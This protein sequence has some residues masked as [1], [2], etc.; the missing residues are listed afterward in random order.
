MSTLK[1]VLDEIKREENEQKPA[2]TTT[3]ETKTEETATPAEET[4]PGKNPEETTAPS[5]E[6]PAEET[7]AEPEQKPKKE[8][9]DDKFARAEY[10]FKRQLEKQNRK[11]ADELKE[12]D[13]KYAAL[14]KKF[15]D[16]EKKLNPENAPKKRGDF[17][18]DDE[19]IDY[20]VQNRT[21]AELD[22][23]R[24]AE[25]KKAAEEAEA[26]RKKAEADKEVQELHNAWLENVHNAF[27]GDAER[28]K[29]FLSKVEYCSQRG[30]GQ[31]LDECPVAADFLMNNPHGPRVMEKLLNDQETFKSV[32]ANGHAS[33]LD[34]YY[35]LRR[36]DE[37]IDR[38]TQ[39]ATQ[40]PQKQTMPH[41]GKPGK[42]AGSGTAPD[43]FSDADEMRSFVRRFR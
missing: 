3:T 29:K 37:N 26:A 16:L 5:E 32:F 18:S 24:E 35:S 1:D 13:D 43:I 19:Y 2:E 21:N 17:A 36:I 11:H 4:K 22:K 10:S 27:D 42:Q 33:Q 41:L 14:E 8:I 30:L 39:T 28:E 6:K 20:L 15:A 9:P 25:S 40:T 23:F 7:P 31:I 12:R 34:I 38:E